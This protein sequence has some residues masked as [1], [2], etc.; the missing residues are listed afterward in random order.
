M[1]GQC[2]YRKQQNLGHDISP[3]RDCFF[4]ATTVAKA[5]DTQLWVFSRF[6]CIV[7]IFGWW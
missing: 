6:L 4:N 3:F 2:F 1:G 5:A 7:I